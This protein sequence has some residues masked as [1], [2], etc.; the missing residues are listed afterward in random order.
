MASKD[1]A[2]KWK[3]FY[4]KFAYCVRA[5]KEFVKIC[6]QFRIFLKTGNSSF[7]HVECALHNTALLLSQKSESD[8]L[9]VRKWWQFKYF[10]KRETF[11]LKMFLWT[12]KMQFRQSVLSTQSPKIA[13]KLKFSPPKKYFSFLNLLLWIITILPKNASKIERFFKHVRNYRKKI[14]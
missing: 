1:K 6:S 4:R 12:H 14:F 13:M 7:V 11:V 9:N 2:L 5:K 8:L 10:P 3:I